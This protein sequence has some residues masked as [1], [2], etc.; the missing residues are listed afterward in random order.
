MQGHISQDSLE[1]RGVIIQKTEF[2]QLLINDVHDVL[3]YGALL[4]PLSELLLNG[5]LVLLL[6]AQLFLDDLQLLLQEVL[7][8]CLFDFLLHLRQGK[9]RAVK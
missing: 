1:L 6:Q 5:I 7:P 4:Q 9:I 3:G 8:V 2:V